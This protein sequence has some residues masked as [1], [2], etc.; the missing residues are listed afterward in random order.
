VL[1]LGESG[2]AGPA[3][4]VVNS[5][6]APLNLQDR[7]QYRAAVGTLSITRNVRAALVASCRQLG[8]QAFEIPMMEE[9]LLRERSNKSRCYHV[10]TKGR[11]DGTYKKR[12]SRSP[13]G[14][15]FCGA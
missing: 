4:T 11:L 1:N 14:K 10:S 8:V 3:A 15:W 13:R 12:T 9:R 7:R 6:C 5:R 2:T